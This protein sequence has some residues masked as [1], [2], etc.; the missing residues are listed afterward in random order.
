MG[1][2]EGAGTAGL[3]DKLIRGA[4]GREAVS[5]TWFDSDAL[6]RG[7]SAR[8]G[9]GLGGAAVSGVG[10][11]SA[12]CCDDMS[13]LRSG[14]D[15]AGVMILCFVVGAASVV[16]LRWGSGGLPL[17]GAVVVAD[18]VDRRAGGGGGCTGFASSSFAMPF[19]NFMRSK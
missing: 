9:G 16:D 13:G 10:T 18:C 14:S 15:G 6:N 19:D 12:R 4:V 5:A 1:T 7:G 11:D 8:R 2:S 3:V 17:T